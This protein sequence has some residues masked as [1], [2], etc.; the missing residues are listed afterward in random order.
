MNKNGLIFAAAVF[1]ALSF[2]AAFAEEAAVIVVS[3]SKIEENQEDSVEKVQVVTAEEIEKSGAKTLSEAVKGIPGV[4]VAGHPADSISMQGFDGDYVKIM[5]DGIAVSGDIGGAV[6]VQQIPVADIDHIEIVRGASS[7]LYGSDAMGGVVNIITKKNKAKRTSAL[8]VRGQLVEEFSSSVR[9]YSAANVSLTKGGFTAG[10][11]GSF[12]WSRGKIERIKFSDGSKID[13]Y[14]SP[15]MQLGFARATAGYSGDKGK[16]DSYFLFS[17]SQQKLNS[18]VLDQIQYKSDRFEGGVSGERSLSDSVVLSGFTAVKSYLLDTDFSNTSSSAEKLGNASYIDSESEARVSWDPNLINSVLV[19]FNANFQTVAG[20]SFDGR[21]KQLLLSLF[22]QDSINI[23]AS[24]VFFIVPG[25]RLDLSPAIDGSSVLFQVT[26]KISM[27][28]NPFENAAF[29]FFY[30]MGY[31]TPSLKEKHWIFLHGFAPG[32]GNFVLYGNPDLKP[33]TSHGFNVSYEQKIAGRVK[34]SAAAYFNYVNNLIDSRVVDSNGLSDIRTYE[35]I[36]KA[37]T[38]GGDAS[39][40]VSGERFNARLSYAYTGAKEFS[41]ANEKWQDLQ[42]RIPHALSLSGFYLIP[43]IETRVNASAEWH[44]PSLISADSGA[45]SPD[46]LL[47][48]MGLEKKLWKDRLDVYGRVDNLLNNVH[49]VKGTGGQT[50]KEYFGLH[51]GA[52]F[53]VGIRLN[54]L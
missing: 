12:D 23:G 30:G 6:A 15:F 44:S 54:L 39:V 35:N 10:V 37:M 28:W 50:Q 8:K 45:L 21:K 31:K 16:I 2:R 3:A 52:I 36:D 47:L 26:P 51:Y 17:D 4:V 22:A 27:R 1:F 9:N 19:G 11:L 42:L 25:V 20:D 41:R 53:S 29:R 43:V 13:R 32:G 5:I 34:L 14:V 46:Y 38:Y 49:F 18:S 33:E 48:S 24:D 40:S 7:A